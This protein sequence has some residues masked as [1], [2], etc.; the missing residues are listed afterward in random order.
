MRFR[1]VSATAA[2]EEVLL[3]NLPRVP[4]KGVRQEE[5][6]SS[7]L[8]G[9]KIRNS[10]QSQPKPSWSGDRQDPVIRPTSRLVNIHRIL[11]QDEKGS[12]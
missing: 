2:T 8:L 9:T 11:G 7:A 4:L 1:E 3:P 6:V 10:D 5:Y 12:I